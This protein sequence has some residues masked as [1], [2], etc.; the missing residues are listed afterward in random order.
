MKKFIIFVLLMTLFNNKYIT[1][2]STN[3][4]YVNQLQNQLVI[5]KTLQDMEQ[6]GMFY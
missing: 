1:Y 3:I 6:S 5:D 4:L 2:K